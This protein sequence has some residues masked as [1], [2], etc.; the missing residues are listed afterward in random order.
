MWW[1]VC[2]D[3]VVVGCGG[4]INLIN[5]IIVCELFFIC[6]Y[7]INIRKVIDLYYF[8]KFICIGI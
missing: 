4:V 7:D 3:V 6:F 1:L 5:E 8:L 2:L